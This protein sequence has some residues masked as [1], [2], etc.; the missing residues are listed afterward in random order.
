MP[1]YGNAVEID[2]GNGFITLY[3]HASKIEVRV[4]QT[5]QPGEPIAEVDST[6]RSTGP[7]LHFEVRVDDQPVDPADYLALFA[8]ASD[9]A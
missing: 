5:M 4:G 7:H 3:A 2:H 1:G 6:S 9:D 8:S